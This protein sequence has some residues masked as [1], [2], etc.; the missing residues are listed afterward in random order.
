MP[1]SFIQ[2]WS[3]WASLTVLAIIISSVT[4]GQLQFCRVDES[5]RTD[6]CLA[7]STYHNETSNSEDFYLLVSAKF[8]NRI[9]YAAFGTGA[10]MDGSLMFVL[11]PGA[12]EKDVVMSLRTTNYHYPPEPS[13]DMP[14]YQTIKTWI[15]GDYYNAQV[16]CYSCDTWHRNAADVTSKKQKWIFSNQWEY[17]M[18]TNDLKKPLGLHSDYGIFE[19]D[20]T[21]SHYADKT[22]VAPDLVENGRK[23]IGAEANTSWKPSQLF[24]I[25]G[26]LLAFAFVVVMPLGVAG[27]RSGHPKAFKI[28]WVIQLSSV[29]LAVLGISWG[30]Y[31]SWGHP[32]T[33][34]TSTG[35]HKILGFA[36]LISILLTPMFG[37]LHHVQYLKIRRATAVTLW[38]RRFGS[39]SLGTAWINVILGL[40]I[41]DQPI[42]YFLIGIGFMVCSAYI[43]YSAPTLR[44]RFTKT[45]STIGEYSAVDNEEGLEQGLLRKETEES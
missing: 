19:L 28:H 9:G 27:I 1:F 24:A 39:S 38:H 23:L 37:Y 41:A 33:I 29:A 42:W 7:V 13:D 36:L 34:A 12:G 3:S 21:V 17:V 35:A 26:L 5:L 16:V 30:I 32:I 14:D 2:R 8:E 22:P 31:L 20:M 40:V 18:Q 44:A 43:I 4:A 45:S 15:D 10:T 6:Q 11:Y 25:H